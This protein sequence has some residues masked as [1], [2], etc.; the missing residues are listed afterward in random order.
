VPA[1]L[2]DFEYLFL[3]D[4][5]KKYYHARLMSA[6]AV[7]DVLEFARSSQQLS[8]SLP[9]FGLKRLEDVL[10]DAEGILQYEVEGGRDERMRPQLRV[11]VAGRLH[12][13]CQRCLGLLEYPLQLTNTL[14]VT[15]QGGNA[16]EGIEDPEAPDT[17]DENPE[18]DV[19]LLVED[20]VLLALPFAPRHAEGECD[21]ELQTVGD[22]GREASPFAKL[23]ALKRRPNKS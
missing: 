2:E 14:V 4:S 7:I 9:V 23:A 13:R 11:A 5:G 22:A 6:P 20:E 10:Y 18:L 16:V 3:T 12:L 8:G 17:I 19:G 21:G 1:K 15:P